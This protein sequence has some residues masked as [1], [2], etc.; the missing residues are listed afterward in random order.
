MYKCESSQDELEKDGTLFSSSRAIK[1]RLVTS[2]CSSSFLDS[3]ESSQVA[4]KAFLLSFA[5][6]FLDLSLGYSLIMWPSFLHSYQVTSL[7]FF[8][9]SS[10]YFLLKSFVL[11]VCYFLKNFL[12]FLVS[13]AISLSSSLESSRFSSSLSF[14]EAFS[15]ILFFFSSFSSCSSPLCFIVS[16]LPL[17]L[18]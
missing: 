11:E 7:I 2:Y 15:A 10:S 12:K 4:L 8:L 1:Q 16:E 9:P 17:L 13:M 5:P 14:C 18:D 3:E 6:L